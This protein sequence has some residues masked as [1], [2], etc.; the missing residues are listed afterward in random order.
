[1]HTTSPLLVEYHNGNYHV[2]LHH[3]GTKIRTFSESPKPEFPESIDLKI[4]DYCDA[5]C[6]FC[7]EKSTKKGIHAPAERIFEILG[8]VQPGVEIAIGGGNPLSHPQ[9]DEILKVL[10]TELHLIANITVH[11]DHFI[12]NYKRIIQYQK[13]GYLFGIGISIKDL[14][15]RDFIESFTGMEDEKIPFPNHV[16]W[17]VIAGISDPQSLLRYNVGVGE[18][19]LIL[20]Y[21]QYGF[22][23]K[24]YNEKVVCNLAAWN[25]WIR[26][27]LSKDL[28]V[29]FDNLAIEQLRIKD[30]VP[31]QVWNQSYMGD[32][33]I[34]SMYIDAVKDQFSISSTNNRVNRNGKTVEQMY[35]SNQII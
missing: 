30:V 17:H 25:Y 24:Y 22:G 10:S 9:L 5:G 11:K 4:T 3:D 35:K 34:F 13:Q 33:G 28:R 27:I 21:K 15:D 19:V 14:D 2:A 1:M 23:K 7:H 31:T 16:V 8:N 32:D 26:T 29:S 12:E 18:S 20:G 6:A